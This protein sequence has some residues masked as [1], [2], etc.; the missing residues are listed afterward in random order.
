MSS[1]LAQ[2][3]KD[4]RGGMIPAHIYND[5][6]IFECERD[7]IFGRAWMFV[8]HESEIPQP[9]DYVVRQIVADSFIIVRDEQG[10]VRAHVN[11]CLHRGMQVAR[12][13]RGN[14]SHFRCPYHNWSYHNDGRLVG[15]PFHREAYGGDYGLRRDQLRLVAAPNVASYN[16]LIFVSLDPDVEPLEDFLGDFKFYL[17]FYTRK[18]RAGLE[19]WGP[20][21]WR[22]RCN[23]K[24]PAENFA[25]DMYHTPHL[26]ISVVE[27]GLFRPKKVTTRKEGAIYVAGPGSGTTY[28][29]PGGDLHERL[30][31]VGYPPDMIARMADVFTIDQQRFIGED[32]FMPSV[33]TLYPNLSFIHSWPKLRADDDD[34]VV[35][36]TSI[37]LWQPVSEHE[38]EVLS[39]FAVDAAASAQFKEQS[40]HQYLRCFGTTGMQEVD[41]TVTWESLTRVAGGEMARRLRLNSRMG[42][43]EDDT[44]LVPALPR[45]QF[46]GPGVARRGFAEFGQRALLARWADDLE[47]PAC[48]VAPRAVPD[49]LGVQA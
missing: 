10:V 49:T 20:Q 2:V 1:D 42:L 16:G 44:A 46:H 41:D 45:E 24:L 36:F 32:G 38:I 18:S 43:S 3:L 22:L 25:G 21:R 6:K 9:G 48:P 14:A 26:H 35:P 12:A 23:W 7:R 8:G 29:L 11:M 27:V 34:T 5:R 19:L 15:V 33:A 39:W 13:D 28:Q 31:Y 4:V 30:R 47:R 40:R 17:D 37:R